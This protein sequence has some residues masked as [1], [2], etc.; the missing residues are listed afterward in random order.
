MSYSFSVPAGPAEELRERAEQAAA[1]YKATLTVWV[2]EA[3]DDIAAAIDA[4][5]RLAKALAGEDD[6]H[7]SVTISGHAN[8]GRQGTDSVYLSVSRFRP[9]ELAGNQAPA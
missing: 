4:A 8:P 7:V 6:V 1:D 2:D 5:E 9:V 3:D